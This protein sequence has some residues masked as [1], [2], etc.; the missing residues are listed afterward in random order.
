MKFRETTTYSTAGENL[1]SFA[2]L[3]TFLFYNAK[4]MYDVSCHDD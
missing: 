2:R 3:L 1:R 4:M